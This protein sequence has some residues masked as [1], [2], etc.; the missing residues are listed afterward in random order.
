M[1]LITN[2]R[3]NGSISSPIVLVRLGPATTSREHVAL[4]HID[5]CAIAA[6][7][8][9]EFIFSKHFLAIEV[10]YGCPRKIQTVKEAPV[11]W[12]KLTESETQTTNRPPRRPE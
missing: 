1:N 5:R 8:N 10:Q 6:L 9:E 4:S 12:R 2:Q 3:K 7:M 11:A